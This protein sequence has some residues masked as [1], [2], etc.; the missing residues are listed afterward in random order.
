[1]G[2]GRKLAKTLSLLVNVSSGPSVY[3]H[4]KN[5]D[6]PVSER[7]DTSHSEGD[8]EGGSRLPDRGVEGC[9]AKE[10]IFGSYPVP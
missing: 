6:H 8:G 9:N 4:G 10:F 7:L 1:M 5:Q 2:E 3:G